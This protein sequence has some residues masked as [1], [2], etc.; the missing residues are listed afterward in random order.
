MQTVIERFFAAWSHEDA[1]SRTATIRGALSETATYSDP[2]SDG[3]L[4][5]V[6]AISEYVG[7]F[8]ANAPGWSAVVDS[9]DEVN[10]YAKAIVSFGGPGPDGEHMAQLGTYFAE[11]D[12]TGA[13]TALAGFVGG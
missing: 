9:V 4:I 1:G 10:G 2:R 8:S 13:I 5:G 6:E 12:E 11:V 7:Q 3:R